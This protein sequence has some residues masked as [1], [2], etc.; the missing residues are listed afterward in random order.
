VN[1]S[2]ND[3]S[4]I[5]VCSHRSSS[6]CSFTCSAVR[7]LSK[8]IIVFLFV[9]CCLEVGQKLMKV[10]I[11]FMCWYFSISLA[12][13]TVLLSHANGERE[14]LLKE[15]LMRWCLVCKCLCITTYSVL[16]SNIAEMKCLKL[17]QPFETVRATNQ[18]PFLSVRLLIGKLFS[19]LQK[20]IFL[21]SCYS[22]V[23]GYL[24]LILSLELQVYITSSIVCMREHTDEMSAKLEK[25]SLLTF[26]WRRKKAEDN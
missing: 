2:L 18:K 22:A 3:G 6:N 8:N 14:D 5:I 24:G 23:V 19:W 4:N 11:L 10:L 26:P 1:K 21:P 9:F 25:I 15:F 7:P 12:C 16:F 20:I 13:L 17:K